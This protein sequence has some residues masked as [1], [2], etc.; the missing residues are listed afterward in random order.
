[1]YS[2]GLSHCRYI[3][4]LRQSPSRTYRSIIPVASDRIL[5]YS[6]HG[7]S[8]RHSACK[9]WW[10]SFSSSTLLSQEESNATSRG[11]SNILAEALV[12]TPL[13]RKLPV[14]PL[15]WQTRRPCTVVVVDSIS[16]SLLSEL[17]MHACACASAMLLLNAT[18]HFQL[19]GEYDNAGEDS[20]S[21]K[22]SHSLEYRSISSSYE[23][24]IVVEF[25]SS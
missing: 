15:L 22:W 2:G 12:M 16:A 10:S 6:R 11:N 21:Y 14:Q 24:V 7:N 5:C 18:V 19:F 8:S 9:Q 23:A 17:F 1:M 3:F 25:E 4:R 20:S 13:R